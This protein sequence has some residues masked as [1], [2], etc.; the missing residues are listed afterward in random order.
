MNSTGRADVPIA[1]FPRFPDS[2]D[3]S[4]SPMEQY[5]INLT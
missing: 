1:R 3:K 4:M 2:S 5:T